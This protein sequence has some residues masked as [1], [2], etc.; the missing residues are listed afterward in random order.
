[1]M[2]TYNAITIGDPAGIGPEIAIKALIENKEYRDETIIIGS[3]DILQFYSKKMKN[4]YSINLIQST[5]DFKKDH[6][7]IIH[8][9]AISFNHISIGQISGKAGD[10][11]YQ[12]LE[13]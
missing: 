8:G 10:A 1:M 4:P 6:I 9:V 5:D 3:K 7:N 13:K 11:A 12:Y 2:M